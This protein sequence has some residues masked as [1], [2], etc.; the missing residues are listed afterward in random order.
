MTDTEITALAREYGEYVA[1][2]L[3]YDMC[4]DPELRHR[5]VVK[6][7]S[8][9]AQLVLEWLLRRFCLVEKSKQLKW[10]DPKDEL[11]ELGERVLICERVANQYKV[12]IGKRIP[13]NDGWEWSQS[14]KESVVAWMPLPEYNLEIAKEVEG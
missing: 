3:D 7:H 14:K 6:G 5:L 2:S 13:F 8:E 4:S 10:I 9:S 1:N 12:F 11:P